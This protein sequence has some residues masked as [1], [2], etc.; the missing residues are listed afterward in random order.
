[1]EN[2]GVVMVM[3]KMLLLD[4]AAMVCA[5]TSG[6]SCGNGG[7]NTLHKMHVAQ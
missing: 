7:M 5:F 3:I 6:S 2:K 1:M 4:T